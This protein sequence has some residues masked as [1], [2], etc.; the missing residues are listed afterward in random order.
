MKTKIQFTGDE[1]FRKALGLLID[2]LG[3]TETNIFLEAMI[4]RSVDSVKRHRKW[5][6]ELDKNTFFE[7]LFNKK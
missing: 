5:Q 2:N 3:I 1:L 7:E 6:K 4:K